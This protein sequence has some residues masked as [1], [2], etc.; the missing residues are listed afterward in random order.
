MQQLRRNTVSRAIS[1]ILVTVMLAPQSF[2]LMPAQAQTAGQNVPAVA[3]V[4]FQDGTGRAGTALMREATAAAALALED[5]KEYVVISTTDLERELAALRL[6]PPLSTAEQARL[7]QRLHADKVLVGTLSS[8]A[9]DAK[10]GRARASLHLMLLDVGIG[11]YL[12]GANS[13]IETKTVPG[14]TGD[15]AAVT[16]EALRAAAEDAVGKMLSS[17]V[18]RGTVQLVDDQGTV[19]I[20]LGTD[21]GLLVGSELLVMRPTW[22]PDVEQVIMRRIGI[23]RLTDIESDMAVARTVEGAAPSTGDRLYRI[24]KPVSAQQAV[25]R[26]K[27]IKSG[28]QLVAAALLL[29]GLVAVATGPTTASGSNVKCGLVQRTPGDDPSVRLTISTNSTSKAKT[30]GWLIFRAMSAGFSCIAANL[31][32]AIKATNLT[33]WDDEPFETR[34]V[35]DYEITFTYPEDDDETDGSVTVSYNDE[36][37]EE[38]TA[39][40][41]RV[42]RVIEPLTDP[43]YNPPAADTSQELTE[44]D[45]ETDPDDSILSEP[46]NTGG[47]VTFFTSPILSTPANGSS[48]Q[49]TDKVTFAW[50]PSEGANEYRVQVFGSDDASGVGTPLYQSTLVRDTGSTILSADIKDFEGTTTYWWRVGAHQSSD[51]IMPLSLLTGVRQWLY[52]SMRSFTTAETPPTEPDAVRTTNGAKGSGATT[53]SSG[54]GT[55]KVPSRHPS[56]WGSDRRKR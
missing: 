8:L 55:I 24:Y 12:D 4:P 44:P 49:P 28:V 3:V 17:T 31:V 5:S 45:I 42:Q 19:N 16:H 32:E 30:H 41:Y 33:S 6:T 23:I 7:G 10:S 39:Y 26:E 53:K 9:V 35:E 43:G 15:V 22:Q 47:P 54:S 21:D 52:S 27:K 46:S 18:R 50:K 25:A 36:A 13:S 14:F 56:W 40:Y 48:S 11:E 1:Y 37:L 29:L 20:N 38:G 51:P 34:V 2:F